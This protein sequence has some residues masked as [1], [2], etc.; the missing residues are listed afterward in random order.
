[1]KQMKNGVAIGAVALF[2]LTGCVADVA[3]VPDNSGT[4]DPCVQGPCQET[5]AKQEVAQE[6][7]YKDLNQVSAPVAAAPVA[8]TPVAA[9]PMYAQQDLGDGLPMN[10]QPGE[11]YS[12]CLAPAVFEDVEE[13]IEVAPAME[14]TEIIP[15]EYE[16]VDEQVVAKE[17]SEE[18]RVIPA[19]YDWVEEQVVVKE[20]SE[21]IKAI[22]AKYEWQ[23]VQEVIKEASEELK[24]IPAVYAWQEGQVMVSPEIVTVTITDPGYKEVKEQVLVKAPSAKWIKKATHCSPEDVKMGLTDCDTLCYVAVPAMYKTVIK[25]VPTDCAGN[26]AG[27]RE[28]VVIPAEY[29]PVRTKV[30]VEPARTETIQVPAEYR[31]VRKQVLVEPARTETVQIPAEYRNVR[32]K[33]MVEPARTEIV[34]IPAEYKTVKVKKLVKDAEEKV[35]T[36]PAEYKTITKKVKV[37]D[38]KIVWRP[39]LC[40]DEAV[41]SKIREM[42]SALSREGFYT[43]EING[44]LTPETNEALRAYQVERGLPQG[45]GMTIETLESLGIY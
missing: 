31:N 17:A 35:V 9:A 36:I 34:Q 16:W 3:Y 33:V 15:A 21:E 38:S 45:G 22:P 41:D 11:C 30:V 13:E 2:A 28:E 8:A 29:K 44:V 4:Q 6:V 10:V 40:E 26:V 12:R 19:K 5:P 18:I 42:Q 1:M 43:S 23:N 24:A 14:K 39:A 27:C 32:K 20:A 7:A 25:K 37:S